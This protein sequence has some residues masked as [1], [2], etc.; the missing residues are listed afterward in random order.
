MAF[1]PEPRRCAAGEIRKMAQLRSAFSSQL[2]LS[3][4]WR[5]THRQFRMSI[6]GACLSL[7]LASSHNFL[8]GKPFTIPPPP[9]LAR[10]CGCVCAGEYLIACQ[11]MGKVCTCW[12]Q[13][14]IKLQNVFAGL[15]VYLRSVGRS[16]KLFRNRRESFWNSLFLNKS[17]TGGVS[18]FVW[19]RFYLNLIFYTKNIT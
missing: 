19:G 12:A 18:I 17:L 16:F 2:Q 10:V 5:K 13:A 7:W 3:A 14:V 4:D 11:C 9:D 8:A 6:C 1:L 15:S